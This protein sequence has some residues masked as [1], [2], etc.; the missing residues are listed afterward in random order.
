MFTGN[1]GLSASI[2]FQ[3]ILLQPNIAKKNITENTYFLSQKSFKAIDV[4]ISKKLV[5]TAC[6][7]KQINNHFLEEYPFLTPTCAGLLE[8]RGSGLDC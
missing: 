5:T 6:D 4:D 7:N 8:P 1:L 2:S 3:F